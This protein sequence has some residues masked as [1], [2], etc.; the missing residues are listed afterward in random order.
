MATGVFR[1]IVL[2]GSICALSMS[3][4]VDAQTCSISSTTRGPLSC[5]VTTAITTTIHMPALVSVNVTPVRTS[6]ASPGGARRAIVDAAFGVSANRSYSLQI[7][8]S[9]EDSHSD[10]AGQSSELSAPIASDASELGKA[11]LQQA[12]FSGPMGNHAPF[13]LAFSRR[14]VGTDTVGPIRLLVT[15]VAP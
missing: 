5:A 15:I 6:G 8:S 12:T 4:R 7:T 13:V 14:L 3:G 2:Y 11:R 10:F 9:S 1:A